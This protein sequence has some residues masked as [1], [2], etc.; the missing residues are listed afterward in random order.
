MLGVLFG[1]RGRIN[2]L[3]YLG[4][5][6]GL[7]FTLGVVVVAALVPV[8]GQLD[9]IKADPTKIAGILPSALVIVIAAC[10]YLWA[11][12]SLQACRFRDIG[13][14]PVFAIPGFIALFAVTQ[15]LVKVNESLSVLDLIARLALAGILLLWPSQKESAGF[16]GD[17]MAEPEPAPVPQPQPAARIPA[18]PRFTPAPRTPSFTPAPAPATPTPAFVARAPAAPPSFGRRGR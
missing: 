12:F 1:F 16:G 18:A 8:V 11:A 2:R 10:A 6:I 14:N 13:W 9:A 7:G 4:A 5:C 3:Q 17:F 15:S